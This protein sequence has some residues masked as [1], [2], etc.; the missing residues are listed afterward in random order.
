MSRENVERIGRFFELFNRREI[1]A[2][3]ETMATDVEWDVDPEDPDTTIHRGREAARRYALGWVETM[4]T[5]VEVLEVFEAGDQVVAWTRIN[6]RGD[7]AGSQS[8]WTSPSS[9]RCV[10]VSQRASGRRE[11]RPRPSK[12]WGFTRTPPQATARTPGR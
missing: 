6:S 12:P 8:G 5:V 7:R 11:T 4:E 9:L 2:W 1:D 10:M 3:L